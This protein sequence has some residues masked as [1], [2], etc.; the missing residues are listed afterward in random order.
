MN[1]VKYIKCLL[2]NPVLTRMLSIKHTNS[3][4]VSSLKSKCFKFMMKSVTGTG[5]TMCDKGHDQCIYKE[6][7]LEAR[8]LNPGSK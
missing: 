6:V 1:S 3:N 4:N 5:E 7:F 2:C 8:H